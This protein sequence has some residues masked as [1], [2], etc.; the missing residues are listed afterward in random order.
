[1]KINYLYN[2]NKCANTGHVG[3]FVY[4][5]RSVNHKLLT[6]NNPITLCT[7]RVDTVIQLEHIRKLSGVPKGS[8][9]AI[10]SAIFVAIIAC[11]SYIAYQKYVTVYTSFVVK[12]LKSYD[13]I[14]GE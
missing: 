7:Y 5:P 3:P 11:T 6:L 12:P 2:K 10:Y 14:I 1:M 8:E 9:M 4:H 13:Y